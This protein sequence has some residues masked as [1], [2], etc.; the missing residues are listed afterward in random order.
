MVEFSERVVKVLRRADQ[1]IRSAQRGELT[2][3]FVACRAAVASLAALDAFYVGFFRGDST[4]V[5]PYSEDG[6]RFDGVDVQHYGRGGLSAWI[7][8]S[9]RTYRFVEDGGRL[10]RK[11][12]PLGDADQPTRDAVVVPLLDPASGDVV[13]MMAFQS[14][15][16]DTFGDE[17]VA[18][19]EWLARALVSSLARDDDDVE[20]LDLYAVY[21]DLDSARFTDTDRL[22]PQL[23][24][25]L[26][27][28]RLA[29][30][31]AAESSTA[32]E[33]LVDD[34]YHL[35]ARLQDEVVAA[36][37]SGAPEPAASPYAALTAR[38]RQIAELIADEGLTNAQI[39]SRLV[40]SE[41][42]VKGHVSGI[43]RKFGV[44]QRSAIPRHER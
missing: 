24:L 27:E 43:L 12:V 38:E 10:L 11:G 4:L 25:R 39:A 22:L 42:T 28:L 17:A 23:A 31:E 35:C 6:G 3:R 16:P 34:A 15:T 13:G 32:A 8:A 21:P 14:W 29:L 41:K 26:D 7:R 5:I 30:R 36:L 33:D 1:R 18:A 9:G 19:G 40:L 2:D 44:S 20:A 37:L